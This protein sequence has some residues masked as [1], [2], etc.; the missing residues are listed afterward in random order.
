MFQPGSGPGRRPARRGEAILLVFGA[1]VISIL[2]VVAQPGA[3]LA[4]RA[5]VPVGEH[6]NALL[7]S[8]DGSRLFVACASTNAVS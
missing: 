5:E 1:C 8:E 3:R 6:P 2:G 7:L 4:L